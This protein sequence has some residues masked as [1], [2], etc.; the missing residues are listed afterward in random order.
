MCSYT[1]VRG[2]HGP[3]PPLLVSAPAAE[4]WSEPELPTL[5]E[6]Q[7]SELLKFQ[8]MLILVVNLCVAANKE[9]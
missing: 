2:G 8:Y 7:P 6:L 9:Y 1:N 4:V 5:S 3:C